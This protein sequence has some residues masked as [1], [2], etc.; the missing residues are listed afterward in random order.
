LR[1]RDTG[2]KRDTDPVM[3][4]AAGHVDAGVVIEGVQLFEIV[5]AAAE[6]RVDF[7]AARIGE[8]VN[9]KEVAGEK[10][11]VHAR[12]GFFAVMLE[13]GESFGLGLVGVGER[14]K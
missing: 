14:S 3:D 13:G 10:I 4:D 2:K 12:F 8:A 7:V 1:E 9:I 11:G 6:L 5:F